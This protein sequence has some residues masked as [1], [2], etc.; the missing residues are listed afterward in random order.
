MIRFKNS[1]RSLRL[2]FFT[3]HFALLAIIL[4]WK[5]AFSHDALK[6]LDITVF[7]MLNHSLLNTSFGQWFWGILNHR[8]ETKLNL[9]AAG[10]FNTWAIIATKDPVLQKTRLKK[11]L[12]FWVFFQIGVMLFNG[13]FNHWL[14][15]ERLSPS[16]VIKPVVQL[17]FLWGDPNIKDSSAHSFPSGHAFAMFYWAFFTSLCV[18]K[19]IALC[20]LLFAC[21]LSL[22]RLVSGAHWLSDAYFSILFAAIWLSWT[23]YFPLYRMVLKSNIKNLNR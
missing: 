2:L 7:K 16:L 18:P 9:L 10:L 11:T 8:L 17:S 15:W 5:M 6:T 3:S 21:L 4:L 12:Y 13:I 22:P 1:D 19:R 20:A 23:L 14:H